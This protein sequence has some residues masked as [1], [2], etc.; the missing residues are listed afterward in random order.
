VCR[1]VNPDLAAN[2]RELTRIENVLCSDASS[3]G[4][5]SSRRYESAK[6]ICVYLRAF[7]AQILFLTPLAAAPPTFSHDIAPI[8]Y[9]YCA[10]CH[11]PGEAGPF[12]LLTYQD[13][14]SHAT[15][16]ADVTRR[17]FMPPWL[18]VN[19][20]PGRG[21][22]KDE[23][24][25]TADQIQMI[26]E[27][28]AAGAPEGSPSETPPMPA[29]TEGWQ[30]GQPDLILEAPQAYSLP[31]QLP[32]G[33]TDLYWNFIF[34][35]NIPASR[36][37]RAIEIRP[38]DKRLVHHANLYVDRSRSA[39][40]QEISPGAGFPGMDPVIERTI[41]EPDDGAFLYWKPG[42][43]PYSEPDGM[44]WRLDPGSD[45]VLNAHMQPSGKPEQVRPSIGL[46]FT[47]K[48]RKQFPMLL[49]LERDGAINIPPGDRDFLIAD[50]FKLPMDVYVLAI[51]PHAHNLGHVLEAYATLP[52]SSASGKSPSGKSETGKP[53]SP[54]A[55]RAASPSGVAAPPGQ[56]QWL[57]RIPNWDRN[58][59]AVYRYKEPLFLPKN[60]VIS[61]RFH[62][63]N[64]AANVRNPHDPPQRVRAGNKVSDEMGHLW[65]Q[66]LP[67][68][69]RDH[70]LELE[71]AAIRHTLEK[72]PKDARSHLH[73][74]AIR[75]AR[76]DAP[77]ALAEFQ[78]AVTLAPQNPEARNMAGSAL[79]ALGRVS[80]ATDQ[81]RLA[82]KLR[83]DYQNARYNLARALI[84]AGKPDEAVGLF[85]QV[86]A[87]YP[88][89]AQ[90]HNG[91]GEL[92]FRQGK[93]DEARAEFDRAIAIDPDFELAKKNRGL[94]LNAGASKP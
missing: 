23:L 79:Q 29:F 32:K 17:R 81:F 66:V 27:W 21:V 41:F 69:P 7:A 15:Q 85:R 93:F 44:A 3:A 9:Q 12:P 43:I 33:E 20:P 36:W 45:L 60:T 94:A 19:A 51:Y 28:A 80:E 42:G 78:T 75:L 59:E 91:L 16:I 82:L 22:F 86:V 64:S 14:K 76:L 68:E 57:I 2:L 25:L 46:Y 77:G 30:L 8:V 50:D 58:W 18:P 37:V 67:A 89:D 49:D 24:R 11:R 84:R 92:L 52:A 73:L 1:E 70:R 47:D 90:A 10:P 56:R 48:P 71:E 74:G 83:P 87:A 72:Y 63:D 61:M 5:R 34:P 54:P 38:G 55:P 39:R 6:V 35:V 13:V 26:G 40:Q 65:L 4:S 62:Y 31:A 88:N 53:P